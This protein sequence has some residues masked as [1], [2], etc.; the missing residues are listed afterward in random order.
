MIQILFCSSYFWSAYAKTDLFPQQL[1]RLFILHPRTLE[2]PRP[3]P[4][5]VVED[6]GT[7]SPLDWS[8]SSMRS[9]SLLEI[10]ISLELLENARD[11]TGDEPI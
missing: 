10:D 6:Q 1:S 9:L 11:L 4:D 7:Q 2:L 3:G 5:T 8:G